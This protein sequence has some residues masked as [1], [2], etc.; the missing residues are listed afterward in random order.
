MLQKI[1]AWFENLKKR[2]GVPE[3]CRTVLIILGFYLTYYLSSFFGIFALLFVLA[4]F[5]D[6]VYQNGVLIN[7]AVQIAVAAAFMIYNDLVFAKKCEVSGA[8]K[9]LAVFPTPCVYLSAQLSGYAVNLIAIFFMLFFGFE[10]ENSVHYAENSI[11]GDIFMAVV[12]SVIGPIVEEYVFRYVLLGKLKFIG[13]WKAILI[14]SAVFASL[15]A[16]GSIFYAFVVGI[17]LAY[18]AVSR[19]I[20]YSAA[21]HIFNNAVSSLL[22][23][24]EKY[25]DENAYLFASRA[26]VAV[27]L[28]GGIISFAVIAVKL[29]KQKNEI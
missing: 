5:G 27:I 26:H 8:E 6:S 13:V 18:V 24:L 16:S 12:V 25:A 2:Q 28:C 7:Y 22:M 1:K 20:K 29:R 17:A 19:G 3:T 23:L 10:P 4:I 14:S 15:H 21:M 9:K 11:Y